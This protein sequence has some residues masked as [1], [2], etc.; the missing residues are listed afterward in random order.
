[1]NFNIIIIII[2][3][4]VILLVPGTGSLTRAA[5]CA[6]TSDAKFTGRYTRQ[7]Q[8]ELGRTLITFLAQVMRIRD[9]T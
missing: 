6:I 3:M 5:G 7:A 2:M 8:L 9:N 4:A 1:M